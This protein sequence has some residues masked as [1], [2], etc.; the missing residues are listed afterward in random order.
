VG[1]PISGVLDHGWP[2]R[3]ARGCDPGGW[4]LAVGQPHVTSPKPH[5]LP[6]VSGGLRTIRRASAPL[7]RTGPGS[8][9]RWA[10]NLHTQPLMASPL[11]AVSTPSQGDMAAHGRG[12]AIQRRQIAALCHHVHLAFHCSVLW[13]LCNPP[14]AQHERCLE[15]VLWANGIPSRDHVVSGSLVPSCQRESYLAMYSATRRISF[16]CMS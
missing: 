15:A 9:P 11:D 4:A 5:R 14:R 7:V 13:L 10:I 1:C 16:F 3:R 6:A 12:C 2:Q 8:W